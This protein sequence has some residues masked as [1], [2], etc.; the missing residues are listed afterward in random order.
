MGICQ[1]EI[2]NYQIAV[3]V[4]LLMTV[5]V[6]IYAIKQGNFA[7]DPQTGAK[8][9]GIVGASKVFIGILLLTVLYPGDC[10]GFAGLYGV[11]AII[12]GLLWLVKAKALSQREATTGASGSEMSKMAAEKV[13]TNEIA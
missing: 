11:I 8:F 2:R 1:D 12:I 6:R 3:I 7:S 10:A 9:F 4:S 5:A 13:S